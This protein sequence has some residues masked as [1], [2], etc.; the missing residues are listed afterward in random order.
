MHA[1]TRKVGWE[2]EDEDKIEKMLDAW[3]KRCLDA[4]PL[5]A[6]EADDKNILLQLHQA[7]CFLV[8][9]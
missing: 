8:K 3:E 5:P 2:E 7:N 6:E 1:W 9:G 4:M